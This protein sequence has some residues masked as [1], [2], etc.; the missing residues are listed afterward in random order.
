MKNP[1]IVAW[2]N[3]ELH[4][5]LLCSCF[6]HKGQVI[7][8]FFHFSVVI[9]FPVDIAFAISATS[10]RANELYD[11]MLDVIKL[12]VDNYG[13]YT[14]HYAF[15]VFGDDTDVRIRFGDAFNSPDQLKFVMENIP[16]IGGQPNLEKALEKA[17][18]LFRP[19]YKGERPGVRK[20]LVVIVDKD[21]VGDVTRY[22]KSLENTGIKVG[23]I[24]QARID[25]QIIKCAYI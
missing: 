3:V 19:G 13:M 2:G 21:T 7:T 8:S 1:R 24:C 16:R 9:S 11:Y 4:I 12:I 17:T 14:V 23:A 6:V 18:E 20:F 15:M 10:A 22:A 5:S 25:S